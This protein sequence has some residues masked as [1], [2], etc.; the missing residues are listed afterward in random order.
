VNEL[1]V[2][3]IIVEPVDM[4]VPLAGLAGVENHVL[5][6]ADDEEALAVLAGKGND[7]RT[8]GGLVALQVDPLEDLGIFANWVGDADA[9]CPSAFGSWVSKVFWRQ[10]RSVSIYSA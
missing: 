7:G 2:S 9:G 6:G 5:P 3:P 4:D 1:E 10:N 8:H